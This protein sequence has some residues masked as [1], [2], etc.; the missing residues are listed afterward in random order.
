MGKLALIMINIFAQ[1]IPENMLQSKIHVDLF[2]LNPVIYPLGHTT[3]SKSRGT[4]LDLI[5]N[6]WKTTGVFLDISGQQMLSAM[7]TE[8]HRSQ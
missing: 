6:T 8:L 5:Q 7:I 2:S 1:N 4:V 3:P